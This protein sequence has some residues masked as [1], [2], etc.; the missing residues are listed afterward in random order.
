MPKP[1][2]WLPPVMTATFPERL[3]HS[4]RLNWLVPTLEAMPPRFLAMVF[5]MVSMADALA[6]LEPSTENP[7][8]SNLG[9]SQSTGR[10]KNRARR[11][12]DGKRTVQGTESTSKGLHF[13]SSVCLGFIEFNVVQRFV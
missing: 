1:M 9:D 7:L 12:G 8:T 10:P 5:L 3:G 4:S 13:K 2:P 6:S 11:L